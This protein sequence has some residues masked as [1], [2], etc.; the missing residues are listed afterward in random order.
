MLAGRRVRVQLCGRMCVQGDEGVKI[1]SS[2]FPGRQG[3]IVFAY[4]VSTPHP[5]PREVLAGLLWPERLPDAWRR[6]LAAVVSKLRALLAR[7]GLDA[8]GVLRGGGDCYQLVLSPR[9][10]VDADAAV[11]WLAEAESALRRGDPGGALQAAQSV[12][13]VA[14]R[15]FLA[16]EAGDWVAQRQNELDGLLLAALEVIAEAA[17]PSAAVG[18]AQ[19]ACALRPLRET[20]HLKLIRAHLRAGNHAE[21]LGAYARCRQLL[22]EELGVDPSPALQAAHLEALRE[23][24]VPQ[25]IVRPPLPALASLDKGLFAGRR[26][27]L[28][29]L[30]G[31]LARAGPGPRM[32]CLCGDPGI[33]KTRLAAEF[34]RAAYTAGAIVLAG[35]CDRE[36]IVPYQPFAEALKHLMAT[37]P[38]GALRA[39]AGSWAAD[40]TRLVPQLGDRLPGLAPLSASGPETA[41]YRL[42]EGVTAALVALSR[43]APL[44]LLIDDLQWADS[45]T[46][47]LLRYLMLHPDQPPLLIVAACRDGEVSAGHPLTAVLADLHQ[48]DLMTVVPLPGLDQSEVAAVLE[49]R[50]M[51]AAEIHQRTAGNPF[52][53]HQLVRHL[54]ETGSD[55]LAGAGV[56]AG[57]HWVVRRRLALLGTDTWR[58]LTV[59]A[60][61]GHRFGAGLVGRV[62][63]L[64]EHAAL[65]GLESACAARLVTELPDGGFAFIHDL[66]REAIYAQLGANRRALLHQAIADGLEALA[67][68][69]V[70]EL[71]RHYRAAGPSVRGKAVHYAVRAAQA[72]AA[73]LAHDDAARHYDDALSALPPGEPAAS[74]GPLLLAL[75]TA[76]R[77]AGDPRA[78]TAFHSAAA[79]ARKNGDT[80]LLAQAALGMAATWAPTGTVDPERT[81]L[82]LEALAAL[83]AGQDQ[84]TAQLLSALARARY[85]E[86][87]QAPRAQLSAQAVAIARHL[88]DPATLATCLDAHNSSTWAPGNAAARRDT[89]REITGLAAS[90]GE[91]ELAVHGHAWGITAALELGDRDALDRELAAYAALAGELRQPRYRWYAQ[92][93][94]AMR[95][96]MTGDFAGG[97]RI[98]G[99]GRDIASRAGEPDAENLL[100]AVLFPVWIE[101]PDNR[102]ARARLSSAIDSASND[103]VRDTLACARLLW[104]T[105]TGADPARY[106]ARLQS[107][108]DQIARPRD[109][110]WAFNMA[111]LASTAARQQDKPQAARLADVLEPYA[112]T[113]IVWAGAAAFFGSAAH[114]LGVL[115]TTLGRHQQA[116]QYLATALALHQRLGAA[117]WVARTHGHIVITRPRRSRAVGQDCA[118]RHR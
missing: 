4:L 8:A 36:Q 111:C 115:A 7:A 39:I 94:Q 107:V 79:E 52:F 14:R 93:R 25:A 105:A 33:G 23:P 58:S 101:Q 17:E 63:G 38:A 102:S 57:V 54:S 48:Q 62:T 5:V 98:A 49:G 64:G 22:A 91:P 112:A 81:A 20:S 2:A 85:W 114:W 66:V 16:G 59:A 108:G 86:A 106:R 30:N 73:Q 40:L 99:D 90:A 104:E 72:A 60:V 103:R 13:E 1:D 43:A 80:L 87:D 89:A 92:S 75:G 3:R 50:A 82:L 35:R 53:V 29:R 55:S 67:P 11:A 47:A 15:P 109:M 95:A 10:Q 31:L 42:F 77:R 76:R 88:G 83:P 69:S 116:E 97:E 27:E 78:R 18:A 70:A 6:D 96:I 21:A 51:L 24:E 118:P 56:P 65:K 117:P 12:A 110:H 9:P 26:A 28:A 46:L 61:I 45:S 113:G 19:E 44:V 74:R 34:A 32:A 84:L 71:A 41:R 37:V 100:V 68:G